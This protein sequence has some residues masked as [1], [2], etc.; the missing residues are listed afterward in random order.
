MRENRTYGCHSVHVAAQSAK[1]FLL[2]V[3]PDLNS[4]LTLAL[5]RH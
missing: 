4:K 3:K 5:A 2:L 1:L